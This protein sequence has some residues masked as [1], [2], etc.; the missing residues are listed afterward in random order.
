MVPGEFNFQL[1]YSLY[2]SVNGDPPTSAAG[3]ST[4]RPPIRPPTLGQ[5][6]REDDDENEDDDERRLG[7][8]D[9]ILN[10]PSTADDT[11]AAV[12][13]KYHAILSCLEKKS[14]S[15][16]VDETFFD[17]GNVRLLHENEQGEAC[18]FDLGEG[19]SI[20]THKLL[21]R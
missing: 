10:D 18:Q 17:Y 12:M 13:D 14:C 4:G 7:A 8:P 3:E 9:R 15:E 19:Y 1:L 6:N 2:G 21:V 11:P 16:C 20:Q 5:E